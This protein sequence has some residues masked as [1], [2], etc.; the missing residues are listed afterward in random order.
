MKKSNTAYGLLG[1][2]ILFWSTVASAFKLALSEIDFVQTLFYASLFS[3]VTLTIAVIVLRKTALLFRQTRRDILKS[4]GVGFLNPF[5]YYFILFKVFDLLPAQEAQPLNWTWPIVLTLLSVPLLKQELRSKSIIGVCISFIGVLVI[6][7]GGNP[8]NLRF[9]NLFGDILA[10]SSSLIWALFWI[11][12]LRDTREPVV[13]L[14][15][16]FIFGTTY[17]FIAVII[18]SDISLQGGS[19]LFYTIYIGIFEMGLTFII[20]LKALELTGDNA[21][22]ANY[23]YLTPFISLIFIHYVVGETILISSVSGLSL[24]I[25]GILIGAIGGN[26]ITDK[27]PV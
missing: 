1:L 17:S 12:N 15:M 22:V 23:A 3:L 27:K 24:I 25:M 19:G 9:T 8:W 5:L 16:G 4:A 6:S 14:F 26:I 10:V 20:W 13:K 2:A 11:F 7:T 18:L 21:S